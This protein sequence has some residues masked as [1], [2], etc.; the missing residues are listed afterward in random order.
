VKYPLLVALPAALVALAAGVARAQDDEPS[1]R[2][3]FEWRERWLLAQ[4]RLTLPSLSPDTL[5]RGVTRVRVDL[6][7]GNDFGWEGD[8]GE[9]S[10]DRRF[11][12]DG[13]HRTLGIDVRRGLTDRLDASLRLPVEWRGGGI[14][15]GVIDWFH[16]FTRKLGLPDNERGFFL[17]NQLRVAGLDSGGAPFALDETSGT[18][19]GRIEVGSRWSLTA[20]G[21]SSGGRAALAGTLSLPTGTGPFAGGRLA[22]GLQLVGAHSLGQSSDLF[23][24]L[25]GTFGDA[26]EEGPIQ[27]TTARAHG[28]LAFERRFG[29]RW[30]A[31]AQSSAAGRLVENVADYPGLQWYLALGARLNLDSGYTVEAGFTEN[32]ANQQATTDFGVQVGVSRRFGRRSRLPPE[33]EAVG[34]GAGKAGLQDLPLGL[35]DAVREPVDRHD[36]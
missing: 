10:V 26:P 25:G 3:P 20:P 23:G 13:E 5:G 36:P 12:V 18:G 21:S 15:D 7:W 19:L 17:R 33:G 11:L 16:E 2:G 31:I 29:R 30:S 27:Y 35:L 9:S 22:V 28:F 1:R 4:P 6:D 32:I 8:P 24:G 14:L 34:E